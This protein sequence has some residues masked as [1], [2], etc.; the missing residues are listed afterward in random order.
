[1]PRG[2]DS[3]A[4]ASLGDLKRFCFTLLPLIGSL[5]FSRG[6]IPWYQRTTKYAGDP[7]ACFKCGQMGHR[8]EA[9]IVSTINVNE[10]NVAQEG[11]QS[12]R[13]CLPSFTMV[14]SSTAKH[15]SIH[16]NSCSTDFASLSRSATN[17][18]GIG[19]SAATGR[20]VENV[21]ARSHPDRVIG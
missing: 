1:M 20:Y 4:V 16:I 5:F 13:S 11:H 15:L 17:T 6:I 8:V 14:G 2:P 18:Q 7:G 21:G 10:G 12:R 3:R 9:H 19:S